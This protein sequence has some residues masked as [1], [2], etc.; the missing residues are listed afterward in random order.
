[1][2]IP[3]SHLFHSII[4]DE[5]IYLERTCCINKTKFISENAFIVDLFALGGENMTKEISFGASLG[6]MTCL[7]RKLWSNITMIKNFAKNDITII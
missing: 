4:V 7:L 3:I 6:V 5:K 1:M 2:Q